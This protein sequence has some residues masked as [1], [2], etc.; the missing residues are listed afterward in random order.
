MLNLI[1]NFFDDNNRR[2]KSYQKIINQINDFET[3]ISKLTDKELSQKTDYFKKQLSKGKSLDDILPEAFAVVR[4]TI[5]RVVGERA[6]DVQLISAITLHQGGI[7]EQRTGEGKTH[8]V[9]FP[10]YLNA[11]TGRGVH[12]ITPNDYLTRV[13]AGWYPKALHFLGIS[14][15]C[16]VHEQSFLLD[17]DFTDESE[18]IDDRLA[19]LKPISRKDAY[20]A[21]ITYGT[22]NEFGFDYLRDHMA[23]D[24]DRVVQRPHYF[25]IV[26][27]VDFVLIDEARTPLII[28]SPNNSPV[29]KYYKFAQIASTAW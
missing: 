29:D 13:G 27:E 25:A 17:P 8:S 9:V 3:K 28:S 14:T 23:Q 6:Y 4:E 24:Q 1:K 21:D 7:A 10:A 22:N 15:A 5:K 12:I 16:I 26:D 20:L 19:H 2:V 11:L 18:K